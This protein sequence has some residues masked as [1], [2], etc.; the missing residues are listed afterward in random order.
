[1]VI[2]YSSLSAKYIDEVISIAK[3]NYYKAIEWDLNN[4][5]PTLSLERKKKII[6]SIE[7]NNL[8]IRY[9][10]PYSFFDI[11]HARID[12]RNFSVLVMKRYLEFIKSLN[13]KYAV[14]HVGYYEECELKDCI[15]SLKITANFAK[16][17]GITLCIENLLKGITTDVNNLYELL[18]I[19]N[20]YLCLD[21]GHANV[22]NQY[23]NNYIPKLIELID[24]VKHS[25]IYYSEDLSFN[26]IPFSK[27][28]I[29]NSQILNG[30]LKSPCEWF[31]MEL[32]KLEEQKLQAHI[33]TSFIKIFDERKY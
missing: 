29:Q 26:H 16:R 28:T 25:H 30:L 17:L 5:P 11:G 20:V 31:T 15:D 13:G 32:N 22:V 27:E 14:I 9:H 33:F 6:T 19:N 21:T 10:L 12:V 8:E 23:D 2:A 18:T 1:M 7:A 3:D 4:I 24:K